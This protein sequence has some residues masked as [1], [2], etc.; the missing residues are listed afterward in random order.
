M[1][2][3]ILSLVLTTAVEFLVLW[4]LTRRPVRQVLIYSILVN[5]L[6]QPIATYVYQNVIGVLWL[7][8]VGVV[9]VE[10]V[11]IM[12]LF[13]FRYGR[14]A[15]LSLAA[16]SVTTLIAILWFGTG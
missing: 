9:L 11:I 14:A 8:E 6:T 12:L 13:K 4:L 1:T 10:S 15:L 3:Y 5:A 2:V 7:V 16:N